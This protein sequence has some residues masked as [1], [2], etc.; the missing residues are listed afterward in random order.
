MVIVIAVSLIVMVSVKDV[1]KTKPKELQDTAIAQIEAT[2]TLIV[3][4]MQSTTGVYSVATPQAPA[5]VGP[6]AG[7]GVVAAT[8]FVGV[9]LN[10]PTQGVGSG[11]V[12][13]TPREPLQ[14]P[15]PIVV[16]FLDLI[17]VKATGT[18]IYGPESGS[19]T[20]NP[21]NGSL[22]GTCTSLRI[23]DFM[24]QLMFSA[25]FSSSSGAWDLGIIFRMSNNGDLRVVIHHDKSWEFVDHKSNTETY[26]IMEEGNIKKMGVN[27]GDTNLLQFVALD[28]AGWIYLN[29]TKVAKLDLASNIDS[30]TICVGIGFYQDTEKAGEMTPYS[31]LSIW[32]LH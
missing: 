2:D 7:P 13:A 28:R 29:N 8:E 17:K 16:S 21:A 18:L 3:Q 15:D 5:V 22:D 10:I 32:E 14:N 9:E 24:L 11:L 30:G 6:V 25:P 26:T 31:D 12:M 1:E 20:H 4:T 23:R 19:F 27:K